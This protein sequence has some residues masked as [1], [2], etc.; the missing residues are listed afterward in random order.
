M[1]RRSKP[2]YWAA[3]DAWYATIDGARHRLARGKGAE[4]EARRAFDVLMG[5][6]AK[7]GRVGPAVVPPVGAVV[8]EYLVYLD[9]RV[10][11]GELAATTYDDAQAR[12]AKF[13]ERFGP[14]AADRVT[15]HE[16]ETWLAAREEWG[17]TRRHD[18]AGAIKAAFRWAT[19]KRLLA[20]NPLEH[21]EKPQRDR[22]RERVLAPEDWPRVLA[23]VV[24]PEFR[25]LLEFLYATGCRP[26]EACRLEARH[27]D[28]ERGVAVLPGKQTAK[29]GRESV[30][31]LPAS[32]TE[33]LVPL[34][35]ERP[36]GPLF[37]TARGTA[38]NRHSINCQVKR[39][40]ERAHLADDASFV[41]YALRHLFATDALE[42]GTPI[43]TVSTLLNHADTRM[44]M[45]H[46]SHLTDRHAHLTA[47]A[48]AIRPASPT[49]R[50]GP[51]A[52]P[53]APGSSASPEPPSGE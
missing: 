46:Y 18:V 52:S 43:A 35:A 27:V 9:R 13:A 10:R 34:L 8:A 30:I 51:A 5:E 37:R 19:A 40:R 12:L 3:R 6:R 32:V 14:A 49:G 47:A 33:W 26:G 21:L 20:A 45:L 25:R 48:N 11:D 15:P 39:L 42:C 2:Y 16:V 22:R 36:T 28:V 4:R 38:W 24:S 17:R 41:A 44:A 31:A 7:T 53:G 23:A 50:P 29:T 1:G